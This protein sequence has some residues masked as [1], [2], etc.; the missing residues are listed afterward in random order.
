MSPPKV[1]VSYPVYEGMKPKPLF[2]NFMLQRRL[3]KD[4]MLGKYSSKPIVHG[5]RNPIRNIRN[6]TGRIA[7][8]CGAD[9]FL[10]IDDDM[11][12]PE[13]I[14][15]KLL[16]AGKDIVA[17]LFHV[18]NGNAPPCVFKNNEKGVPV[19]WFDHPQNE[20]FECDA[21]GSGIMLVQTSVLK[22][23][24][25]PWFFY[26]KSEL[27]MDV[28]FCQEAKK[29]GVSIWCD[30]RIAVHQLGENIIVV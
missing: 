15:E 10:F 19:Q 4:E 12:P 9:A 3:M 11:L 22:K 27:S 20:L 6:E 1:I 18:W 7:I 28:N 8:E 16:E 13:D 14:L 25:K 24:S 2:H 29:A 5:P 21:V 30:S 17:P 26:D 23:L